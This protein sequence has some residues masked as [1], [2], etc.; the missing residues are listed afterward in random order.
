[1]IPKMKKKKCRRDRMRKKVWLVS[2]LLCALLLFSGCV[3]ATYTFQIY[4]N[5]LFDADYKILLDSKTTDPAAAN[6]LMLEL[7]KH[8]TEDKY[9]ILDY[10]ENGFSGIRVSKKQVS[11]EELAVQGKADEKNVDYS[12]VIMKDLSVT[13]GWLT[14]RFVLKSTV[15]LTFLT[16]AFLEQARQEHLPDTIS[17]GGQPAGGT[18]TVI[19]HTGETEQNSAVDLHPNVTVDDREITETK[20]A[21]V[22]L[23]STESTTAK[24]LANANMKIVV[25]F[26]DKVAVSN[27][28]KVSDNGKTLEWIL[29]PGAVNTL[30]AQG[31]YTNT[32]GV[33]VAW[34]VIGL[35]ILLLA[36]A[37]WVLLKK[38]R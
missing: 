15:D 25:S 9:E 23:S 16:E 36:F 6:A 12:N 30:S 13:K 11:L 35:T 17:M 20:D 29:I 18:V 1:M 26:P 38:R 33:A 14:N 7:R 22:A 34:G 19:D 8:F 24:L 31:Q 10:E 27:A 5:G 37:A 4:R 28:G 21:K 32:T 2:V 3:N